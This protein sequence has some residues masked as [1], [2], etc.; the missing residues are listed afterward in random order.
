M[1]AKAII[2]QK[3]IRKLPQRNLLSSFS[4]V[5]ACAMISILL[6]VIEA[7]AAETSLQKVRVG[8][9]SP[10]TDNVL[11]PLAQKQGFFRKRGI[12]SEIIALRGGVQMA[13][14]LLSDSLQF[15]QMAGSVLVRSVQS[16]ADLV[17]IA[18]YVDRISY[19]LVARPE[20]HTIKDLSGKRIATAS[21]GGSVDMVLRFSL[22]VSGI[23]PKNAILLPS[24]PP[25][26]RIAAIASNQMD[27]TIVPPENLDAAEKAGLKMVKD[28]SEL[29]AYVQHTGLVVRRSFLKENRQL[30][31]A[32]LAGIVEAIEFYRRNDRATI[33]VLSKFTGIADQRSVR[34]SYEFHKRLFS[35]PPYPSA[36]GFKTVLAEIGAA[37]NVTPDTFFDRS[38]LQEL[39]GN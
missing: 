27:A 14:A 12:E 3:S 4:L 19:F 31:K 23:D 15:A 34:D 18:S 36:E 2:K 32:F 8:Y 20:I 11:V 24:G 1:C 33:D 26:T 13:Q 9:V 29:D 7:L 38:L 28:L 37:K 39:S 16:G 35:L 21:I 10:S 30:T 22:K 17:M 5:V 6:C 25:M